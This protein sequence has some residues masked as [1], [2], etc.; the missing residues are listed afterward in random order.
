MNKYYDLS[1]SFYEYGWG[2]SFHFAH[3]RHNET[4][5]ESIR[6]HEHYL[7]L[8]LGLKAGMKVRV[9]PPAARQCRCR[10]RWAGGLRART[11]SRGQR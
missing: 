7:A 11:C 8:K 10:R 4:L 9:V 3:R 2:E 1:T 5:R 6:R